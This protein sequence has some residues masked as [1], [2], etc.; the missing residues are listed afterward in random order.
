MTTN[1]TEGS[2]GGNIVPISSGIVRGQ[3]WDYNLRRTKTG[4]I[5]A[6]ITN[7]EVL[8]SAPGLNDMFGFDVRSGQVLVLRKWPH[9]PTRDFREY[10]RGWD[11][12]YDDL[13]A[14][15]WLETMG[16]LSANRWLPAEA[17]YLVAQKRPMN[18]LVDRLDRL[19]SWDG[20]SR[21]ELAARYM[22]G[23][24]DRVQI[25]TAALFLRKWMLGGVARAKKPGC[26]MDNM[27]VLEGLQ[28]IGKT[29]LIKILALEDKWYVEVDNLDNQ[30][31]LGE[32]ILGKWIVGLS[33]L[34]ALYRYQ[35]AN[36]KAS[37]SRTSD[38]YRPA[39]ARASCSFARSAVFAGCTNE[40]V[41]LRDPTGARR[42]W[43]IKCGDKIDLNWAR[44]N[45]EQLWA[46]VIFA[47]WYWK[48]EWWL[49]GIDNLLAI[50]EQDKRLESP[51][52]EMETIELFSGPAYQFGNT[53]RLTD[54]M[55]AVR[56]R[57]IETKGIT[58]QALGR[59]LSE[60]G[61]V[62]KRDK[63]GSVTMGKGRMYWEKRDA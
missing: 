5:K 9:A 35:L 39:Y 56:D 37:L 25:S 55:K 4:E 54:A 33:E 32:V 58:G 34:S 7:A 19:P 15:K 51:L 62:K 41:Y 13:L 12:K 18:L 26:Q 36:V 29:T 59:V 45:V 23:L 47:Y 8:M 60:A 42:F 48:E 49:S 63:D 1:T 24:T 44:D 16:C 3:P 40:D 6:T 61:W 53:L 14:R 57:G 31:E 50:Q 17:A 2:A 21:F 11:D 30:K 43:P 10:P 27:L 28:G 22:L 46:E 52:W 38:S 20:W